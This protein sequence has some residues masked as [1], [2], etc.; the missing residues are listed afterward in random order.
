MD[1]AQYPIWRQANLC[2]LDIERVVKRFSRYHK[3]TLGSELR[4]KAMCICQCIHR[5]FS[6]KYSRVK[7]VQQLSELIDDLKCQIQLAK[8]LRGFS[9]LSQ[10]QVVVEGGNLGKQ[11]GSC[12]KQL[13]ALGDSLQPQ[14]MTK[15]G[16]TFASYW[17]SYKHKDNYQLAERLFDRYT[18]L[19]LL[20]SLTLDHLVILPRYQPQT[21]LSYKVQVSFF[22]QYYRAYY[23]LIQ[24]GKRIYVHRNGAPDFVKPIALM[25]IV[26]RLPCWLISRT[27]PVRWQHENQG[28]AYVLVNEQGDTRV[29]TKYRAVRL[30]WHPISF[31]S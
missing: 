6:R 26:S 21:Q 22:S 12:F 30:I 2:L 10:F 29:Q 1:Y 20:F 9:S 5:A 14:N 8:A 19:Q 13:R 3:Y 25:Q 11:V 23:L 17:R 28:I 15:L 27:R 31:T 4:H 16:A 7:L 18:W 24:C